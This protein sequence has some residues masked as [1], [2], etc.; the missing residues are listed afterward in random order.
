MSTSDKERN[1]EKFPRLAHDLD[2]FFRPLFPNSRVL[3][4]KENGNEIGNKT[5]GDF[6]PWRTA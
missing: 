5:E 6:V 2:A 3:W 4:A 1:R